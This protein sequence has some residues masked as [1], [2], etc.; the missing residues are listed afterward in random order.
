MSLPVSMLRTSSSNWSS[1]T[2][3]TPP[4]LQQGAPLVVGGHAMALLQLGL[5][6]PQGGRSL[7]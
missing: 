2:A 1:C 4:L 3:S 5:L 7:W 6:H